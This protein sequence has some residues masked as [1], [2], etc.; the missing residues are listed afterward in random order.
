LSRI[1]LISPQ[2]FFQWRGSPIRVGFD[3]QALVE[4]GYEVDFLTLPVG[5]EKEIPGV[6]II[7]VPNLFRVRT[8]PIGPSAVKLAFDV[9]LLLKGLSLAVHRRYD[10]IHGVE[11]AGAVGVVIAAVTRSKLVFEKHSDPSSYN[12]GFLRS[13]LMK[14]YAA[15]E[16]RTA[17]YSD[18]VIGTGPGLVEQVRNMN[19][20]NQVFAIPHIPSS[21]LEAESKK[22]EEVRLSMKKHPNEV[23]AMYV[24]SFAVYQGVDL[25][26]EAIARIA[27]GSIAVRFI[28]IGGTPDEIEER[29][30]W[31]KVNSAEDPVSFLGKIP[32]DELPAYLAASDILLSPRL[33][34]VNTPLKILDYFKARGAI[35][36]TDVESNRL[37]LNDETA[38]FTPVDAAGFAAGIQKAVEDEGLRKRIATNGRKLIDEKYNFREFSRVLGEC[39][40]TVLRGSN[41]KRGNLK[42]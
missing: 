18:A 23:L 21:L 2:P 36:A 8:V 19:V 10:V 27:G 4:L 16:R 35:V 29:K 38:I 1:L 41:S 20:C 17:R 26:F 28:I 34:G 12:K 6:R 3:L 9:L 13:I 11:D 37:L 25:M 39:Y 42:L 33:G 32:P 24:G 5:E 7:R 15:V 40:R 14:V 31:L 22:T 30:Q